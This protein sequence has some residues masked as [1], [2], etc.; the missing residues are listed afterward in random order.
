MGVNHLTGS[1]WHIEKVH[2]AEGDDRRYK[3]RCE[4]YSYEKDSCTY[5]LGKCIGSA[6]CNKYKLVSEETFKERQKLNRKTKQRS[7]LKEDDVYWF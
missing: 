3:G 5:R 1:P 2:R 7:T 4:Y 6:H